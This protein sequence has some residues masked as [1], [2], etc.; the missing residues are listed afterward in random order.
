MAIIL[1]CEDS[2]LRALATQRPPTRLYSHEYLHSSVESALTA[3]L[4]S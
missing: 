1:P 4:E 2:Y 3:L